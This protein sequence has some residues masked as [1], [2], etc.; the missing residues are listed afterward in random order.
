MKKCPFCA[1]EIQDV[2]VKCKHCGEWFGEREKTLRN[3]TK[4]QNKVDRKEIKQERNRLLIV[5]KKIN[6]WKL[7]L[8]SLLLTVCIIILEFITYFVF[9]KLFHEIN[10]TQRLI[11]A[12]AFFG[13]IG[14]LSALLLYKLKKT[15]LLFLIS[16]VGL[17]IYRQF[18]YITFIEP[19][20]G[21]ELLSFAMANTLR[22]IGVIFIPATICVYIFRKLEGKFNYAEVKDIKFDVEDEK[23]KQKYDVAICSNCGKSTKVAKERFSGIFPKSDFHFCNNC[24][25]FLREDPLRSVFFGVAEMLMSAVFVI[26]FFISNIT[27][28]WATMESLVVLFLALGIFDGGKKIFFGAKGIII[29]KRYE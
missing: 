2:A 10:D 9:S 29:S 17:L 13:S 3:S 11:L 7:I 6:P 5:L 4:S 23:E 28:E 20:L 8:L 26:A 18:F 21:P 16:T 24:G 27:G 1:E 15:Y 12:S 25:I 19:A 14:I 22:Q